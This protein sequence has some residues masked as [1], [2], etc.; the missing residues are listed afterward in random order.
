MSIELPKLG[1]DEKLSLKL[2]RTFELNGYL[3]FR[4]GSFEEYDIYLQ[5]KSF[6]AGEDVITFTGANGKLM[7]LKPDVTLSIAR[8][9][10][11]DAE[12]KLYYSE[13]VFR[14]NKQTGEYSEI[15]QIGIE[16]IGNIGFEEEAEILNLAVQSLDMIGKSSLQ[17]SH[18]GIVE[19]LL[20]YFDSPY[21]RK[22]AVE[23][24]KAKSIH[25]LQELT[26]EAGLTD[27]VADDILSFSQLRGRF[28][29]VCE[30]LKEIWMKR[31]FSDEPLIQLYE[32]GKRLAGMN[33]LERIYLDF[34]IINNIDYYNG[35]VFQGY[36]DGIPH[37]VLSG[38]RYDN[39][40]K[41]F[42]KSQGAVGFAIYLD[43]IE[44]IGKKSEDDTD[45]T[46]LNIA[47][48]KGRMGSD[49]LEL[50]EMADVVLEGIEE[51]SRKLIFEDK[52]KRI[53]CFL[54]KPSDVGSYVEHGA[55]DIGVVGK[56]ILLENS[57]AIL[58][59]YDTGIGKCR[60]VVAGKEGFC[61]FDNKTLKVASKFPNIAR[62][63]FASKGRVVEVIEL[64]GSIE[65]A[66]LVGLSDVIVDITE[67][68]STLRDNNLEIIS[69][70]SES[71]ARLIANKSAYIFK[72][73]RIN[74]LIDVFK[75]EFNENY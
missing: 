61:D 35:L 7:A 9:I 23:F 48:P 22:K 67:S 12:R 60:I 18:M 51:D 55:A 46:W 75:G 16:R 8:S 36:V 14:R 54:V 28:S 38:G 4:V 45:E 37:S 6:L 50:L 13:N 31:G 74:R 41:K 47:L 73:E 32:L 40:M 24:L 2:R 5:N 27:E 17:I 58:E 65:L 42:K 11:N 29:E 68:G 34:S 66:P 1:N 62:S 19:V 21:H 57:H 44:N 64:Q 25:S 63:Y 71:S 3:L 39:L 30:G 53:R 59:L 10:P 20:Q 56:D 15:R 43:E 69:I 33:I 52:S 26:K 49:V 70:I 72:G